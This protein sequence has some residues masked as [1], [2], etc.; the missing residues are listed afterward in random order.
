MTSSQVLCSVNR[1]MQASE[2]LAQAVVALKDAKDDASV[3]PEEHMEQIIVI[4]QAM[5]LRAAT[6]LRYSNRPV[7]RVAELLQGFET[8]L[9]CHRERLT[10]L[11]GVAK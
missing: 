1:L 11:K 3:K 8:S 9:Q 10:E 4:T 5:A 6:L 2:D 7:S